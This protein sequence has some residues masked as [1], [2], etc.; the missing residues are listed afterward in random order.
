[1]TGTRRI[2]TAVAL[3]AMIGP[4]VFV[5]AQAPM[6]RGA[7]QVRAVPIQVGRHILGTPILN[8]AGAF[9]SLPAA[10][11]L[12]L[13]GIVQTHAGMPVPDAGTV[14]VRNLY[15]GHVAARTPVNGLAQ[16]SVR[17]L[18]PGVYTADLLGANGTVL[19]SSPA[20]T[21][22]AGEVIQLAQTIQTIPLQGVGRVVSSATTSALSTAAS[23]GVLA[24]SPG[25]PVTPGS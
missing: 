3:A 11:G 2:V 18:P 15:G 23:S 14:I 10:R 22:G 21:G 16:F 7:R 25:A 13:V 8:T 20:F 24:V 19:A 1:M 12:T 6:G 9:S 5:A 4:P 17:G